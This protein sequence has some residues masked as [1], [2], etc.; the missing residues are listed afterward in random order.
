MHVR[1][2]VIGAGFG[3]LGAA[4]RLR[5]MGITD[6]VVLERA[7]S[8]G[9][10]W[11]DNTYPGCACDVPSHLYSFSFAPNAR[12]PR[13][14]SGQPHIRAYLEWVTDTFGLRPHIRFNSEVES[15]RWDDEELHW[16]VE[17][18]SGTYTADVVVS[19]CGP[20][21]DPR[22]PDIPGLDQFPGHVFHS[23]R[24]D[25]D[26]SLRGK[27]VAVVGTGASAIQ[28][29][30]EIV[31]EVEHLTVFQRTAPWVLP[32]ADRKI[33][34]VER[35]LHD[36]LPVTRTMRRQVLWG[37]REL[38]VGAFAKRPD[39]MRPVE[40]VGKLNMRRAI[41]DPALRR[42][43]TPDY[44][45][46]CK[47]ILLSNDWY[48]ALARP[49]VDVVDAG[50]R[51]IRGSTL[52]SADGR[53]T[54]ADVIVF[55]TGFQVTD[56]PIASRVKGSRG[57]T[58]AEEWQGGMVGLRGTTTTGFPNLLTI[59]GPNTGLGNS[60]MILII[61]A[62]LNYLADFMTKLDSLGEPGRAALAARPE[63]VSAWD[64]EMQRRLSRSVWNTG[65][66][67]SWYLGPNGR[68]STVWPGT[69]GEFRRVTQNV[70][71][72]EYE[73]LRHA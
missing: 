71:L 42:R 10:A 37:L 40:V 70:E 47:R 50:L 41:K 29:V 9:G 62:Q 11:R 68:N 1:V 54:E 16:V 72:N 38:Q 61:E 59:I 36:K 58:L 18:A 3:G 2:A 23:A 52:I 14:F 55:G 7:E 12:W 27:R 56:M 13:N 19:A 25:H 39:L 63:A 66:C 64:D 32:R 22:L 31:K 44:R 51:E 35:W 53:E 24:W 34:G 48:P 43:L 45:V 49:H 5:R 57:T 28:F 65:G 20:L 26:Y 46:G 67:D 6:F 4:A 30:P 21:S 15:A 8:V 73:V 17:S 33:T 69:T 60:S